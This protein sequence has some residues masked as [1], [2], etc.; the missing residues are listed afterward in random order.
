[1][2]DCEF[3]WIGGSIQGESIFGRDH[4]TR[5]GNGVEIYGACDNYVVDNCY[6]WQV[7]DAGVTQQV[8]VNKA[9]SVM[10]HKGMR[11][12]NNVMEK[13]NYSI[14]YFRS[15]R[16]QYPQNPSRMEDFLIENNLMWDAAIGFCEQ[17][18]DHN[19]GAHVKS[20]RNGCNRATRFRI[21]NNL[22][23]GSREML[24]E[25]SSGLLNP[26]GSDSMPTLDGNLFIGKKGQR[27]GVLNQGRPVD[28]SYDDALP[29]KL[30]ARHVNNVFYLE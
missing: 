20:W 17:R 19:C 28:L 10:M 12:S 9:E 7:Y 15:R 16:Q 24:I 5:L 2:R 18:P 14:E 26:D 13:C 1:V 8:G 29:G 30:D 21:R 3:G 6:F 27:F 25:V 23:A 22:F 4:P 11:Y